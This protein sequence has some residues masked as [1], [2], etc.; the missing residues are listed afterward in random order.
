MK[1][2]KA[3]LLIQTN[4][5]KKRPPCPKCQKVESVPIKEKIKKKKIPPKL[6]KSPKTPT[7]MPPKDQED[8]CV[9]SY[10]QSPWKKEFV[11]NLELQMKEKDKKTA[12]LEK[13]NL[14]LQTKYNLL[15][16]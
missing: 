10:N 14:E 2:I 3:L 11:A 13:D 15:A 8:D 7:K 5:V 12:K 1:G 9:L 4:K 16:T 6:T